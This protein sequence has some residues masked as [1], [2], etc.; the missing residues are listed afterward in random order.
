MRDIKS[1]SLSSVHIYFNKYKIRL[2][3][4]KF[5]CLIS[6]TPSDTKST[7]TSLNFPLPFHSYTF[8]HFSGSLF[9]ELACNIKVLLR[10]MAC[11]AASCNRS[12]ILMPSTA[13]RSQCP[14]CDSSTQLMLREKCRDLRHTH[15][16]NHSQSPWL[17]EVRMVRVV[18]S[19]MWGVM[20]RL[21]VL[22]HLKD[23][24]T[25]IRAVREC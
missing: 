13:T 9:P 18:G 10:T 14:G 11:K 21:Y 22:L 4:I 5:K 8:S 23:L 1:T 3:S 12:V 24:G 19:G 17:Y 20:G 15:L 7:P 16:L 6:R 25:S 2:V